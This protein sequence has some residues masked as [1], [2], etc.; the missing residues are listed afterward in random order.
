M[1]RTV[2]SWILVGVFGAVASAQ[3]PKPRFEVASIRVAEPVTGGT[4]IEVLNAVTTRIRPDGLTAP[5]ETVHSLMMRSYG[6]KP[7]QIVSGLGWVQTD[8]FDV[9]R[10]IQVLVIDSVSRPTEN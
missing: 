4:L 9:N 2:A 10:P 3:Q 5:Y 1:S 7:Y 6:L 8:R